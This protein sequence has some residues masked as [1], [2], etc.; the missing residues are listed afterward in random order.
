STLA[1]GALSLPI[2]RPTSAKRKLA[3]VRSRPSTPCRRRRRTF[4]SARAPH[5]ARQ[6]RARTKLVAAAPTAPWAT[7]RTEA[8]HDDE[9]QCARHAARRCRS[10]LRV[11]RGQER[12]HG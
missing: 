10:W 7:T 1:A 3:S 5:S 4:P 11:V 9:A 8:H 12:L 6:R 2:A